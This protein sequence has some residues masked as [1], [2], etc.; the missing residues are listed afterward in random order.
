MK[1]YK[2]LAAVLGLT[3]LVS[4]GCGKK[5]EKLEDPKKPVVIRDTKTEE[6]TSDL[7]ISGNVKPG[8]I[9][10]VAFKVPGTIE[11]ISVEEGDRVSAGDMLMSLDKT[12]F[13]I[14]I[15]GAQA[16][17]DSINL[18]IN[19]KVASA[20]SQAR[21]S[22][23]FI[24]TQLGRLQRLYEKGAVAKKTVEEVELQRDVTEA[25]LQEV[26][27]AKETAKSQ[28]QQAQAL[29]DMAHSKMADSTMYSPISGTV[30]KKLSE[31]GETVIPGY[32][33]IALGTLDVLDVEIGVSDKDIDK[34]KLDQAVKVK[35]KGLDKEIHGRV[36]RIEPT[37]DLETRTFGVLVEIDNAEGQIKPGMIATVK[38]NMDKM[39]GL[40]IPID[41]II[42]N[43][44]G[45]FVFTY[46][47][48]SEKVTS[49]K[50]KT[51]RVFGDKIEVKEGLAAGESVV[52]E[53][54]YRI[55]DG[56]EVKARGEN[57]D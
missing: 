18:E 7:E 4:A 39:K 10:K 46:D 24:N 17:Y 13:Q 20:E 40:T 41:A 34:I 2:V 29:V 42:D 35:I 12:D 14:G 26:L 21:S 11:S 45:T 9:V 25:K 54:Q 22:L 27:D 47:K 50:I 8:K 56:E 49:K 1:K 6:L 38:I 55:N 57:D 43:A 16:K 23:D 19:S 53:G 52:V 5:E 32:P 31:T 48:E 15:D 30:V 51:G 28:L 36:R 3:M 44:E 33:T 37:A